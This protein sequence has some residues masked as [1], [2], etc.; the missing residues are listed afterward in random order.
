MIEKCKKK[1]ECV[2]L[3]AS[4]Y[5][6]T[7]PSCGTF[8]EEIAYELKVACKDCCKRFETDPPVHAIE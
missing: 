3:I 8:N 4:G 7:C 2:E 5:E 6:W 1:I